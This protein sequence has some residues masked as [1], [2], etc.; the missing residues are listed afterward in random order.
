MHFIHS[1]GDGECPFGFDSVKF[2][3]FV[4]HKGFQTEEGKR[5]KSAEEQ[6]E[7]RG[8]EEKEETKDRFQNLRPEGCRSVFIMRC[9]A[10][11]YKPLSISQ[12]RLIRN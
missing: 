6:E 3:S 2:S 8:Y 1:P 7:R 12:L 4:R 5:S 10:V 11:C 9:Y